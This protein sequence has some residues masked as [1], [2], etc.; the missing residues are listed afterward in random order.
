MSN[1]HPELFRRHQLNPILTVAG[2]PYPANSVFNPG[3]TL[4]P[5]GITL[6]LCRVEDRR[7]HS[8]FCVA[9]SA[10]GVDDWQIAPQPTLLPDPE[11]FPEEAWGLEDPRITWVEELGRYAIVYT[12][13]STGGPLVSLALTHD[14]CEFERKGTLIPPDSKDAALF[15]RRFGGRWAL[16]HRPI[17]HYPSREGNIWLSFSPDL[18]HWGDH[19]VLMEARHGAW[20]DANK[21]GL[22][23]PP[24]ETAEGWLIIYHGVR[25]T[26]AGC[27][28]RLGLA[29][30]DLEDP[31]RVIRRS[32][33]S[34]FG[35][36]APYERVGDVSN[37]V[38]PCGVILDPTNSNI[39]LY[40]G[41]ADTSIA[42]A[43]ANLED[44]LDWLKSS[45]SRR[46][47]EDKIS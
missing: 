42:L 30:L 25:M 17:T 2:W 12:S 45:E 44:L 33:E 9:R 13:F 8:H 5:D 16:L 41:A 18:K 38:F 23:P 4:L 22:A 24:I 32:D 14:F 43:T 20:W 10:N 3:A 11:H 29:L 35:A 40:Y 1:Q 31:S 21:I 6:L 19:C 26:D 36:S 27:F 37:V 15:P 34:V 28:Y 7:G 46:P 47:T 39:R